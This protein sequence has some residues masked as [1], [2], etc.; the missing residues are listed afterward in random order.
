MPKRYSRLS[1][2][3]LLE[4]A[5]N[6]QRKLSFLGND[7]DVGGNVSGGGMGGALVR[8]YGTSAISDGPTNNSNT[9]DISAN[10]P[11]PKRYE[12]LADAFPS[13]AAS[14]T[15]GESQPQA[16]TGVQSPTDYTYNKGYRADHTLNLGRAALDRTMNAAGEASEAVDTLAMK[17]MLDRIIARQSQKTPTEVAAEKI[18]NFQPK[19]RNVW[20]RLGSG[21]LFGL[22][23]GGVGGAVAGAAIGAV[24]AGDRQ[25]QR[26]TNREQVMRDL[27]LE[28]AAYQQSQQATDRL[29]QTI[30]RV[31]DNARQDRAQKL[32][33]VEKGL[34]IQREAAREDAAEKRLQ[35]SE[36]RSKDAAFRQELQR[37]ID[38]FEAGDARAR[39]LQR[40]AAEYGRTLRPEDL[41]DLSRE[42]KGQSD[43]SKQQMTEAGRKEQ[44]AEGRR[45]EQEE[46]QDTIRR[47]RE[48][49]SAQ[50]AYDKA[51]AAY[52]EAKV[53][54]DSVK[55][56]DEK[57]KA[58]AAMTEAK[59]AMDAALGKAAEYGEFLE[60]GKDYV[61]RKAQSKRQSGARRGKVAVKNP[62]F[63]ARNSGLSDDDLKLD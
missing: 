11:A 63:D 2:D 16:N 58:K 45:R 9:T 18:K 42:A 24:P 26:V 19:N 47:E 53:R 10:R 12:S 6:P 27:P 37:V 61:K 44:E 36:A 57:S 20:Q 41:A 22:T 33:A 50:D 48:A 60:V 38:S 55:D 32:D 54:H 4:N 56:K 59:V 28:Q 43:R 30:D 40:V 1:A 52:G 31:I 21:A 14:T 39:Q 13:D 29:S 49:Y 7:E 62:T 8:N 46:R 15:K 34:R 17:P 25:Q 5:I 51:K 23:H 35:Q 3:R